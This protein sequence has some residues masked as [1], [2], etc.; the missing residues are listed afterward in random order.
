VVLNVASGIGGTIGVLV[1]ICNYTVSIGTGGNVQALVG[2]AM[3]STKNSDEIYQFTY[4]VDAQ[5]PPLV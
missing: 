2:A 3:K 4:S 5:R 1:D